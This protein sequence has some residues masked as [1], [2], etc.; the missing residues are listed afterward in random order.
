MTDN[1]Q[2][3]ETMALRS[4]DCCTLRRLAGDIEI[5]QAYALHNA[6]AEN[7]DRTFVY[8]KS[9]KEITKLVN[10]PNYTFGAMLG[11]NTEHSLIGKLC[12][13]MHPK[14]DDI[15]YAG[16]IPNTAVIGCMTTAGGW[17]NQGLNSRLLGYSL[18]QIQ[19]LEPRLSR[20]VA[21]STYCNPGSWVSLMRVGFNIIGAGR[22]NSDGSDVYAL[23]YDMCPAARQY[24]ATRSMAIDT[25]S[26]DFPSI[27][28]MLNNGWRAVGIQDKMVIF[29]QPRGR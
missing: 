25:V 21:I 23:S 20:M 1:N 13:N 18:R 10:A 28:N 2:D 11:N 9:L 29:M 19:S 24:G 5:Q 7:T 27:Q 6:V 16:D 12:V 4:G 22:D 17:H 15:I 3:T 26:N 8:P 14:A